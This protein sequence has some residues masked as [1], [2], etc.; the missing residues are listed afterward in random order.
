MRKKKTGNPAEQFNGENPIQSK[1]RV[2]TAESWKTQPMP[3]QHAI[4]PMHETITSE[5][6][7]IVKRGH[8][9]YAMEDHWFM[10][11]DENTIRYYRSWSGFCIYVAKYVELDGK[12]L[13]TQLQ[14]N[15]NPD[16]Y[17]NQD[18]ERDKAHF[19]ALLTDE[20]G[21]NSTR[22]WDQVY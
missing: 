16:Q 15:R 22:Y 8:L 20:Y 18:N 5:A 21:G 4:I 9:P 1:E 13:I 2:A 12:C 17:T 11:C 3:E 14:V 10:Y 7:A 6:M 19:M